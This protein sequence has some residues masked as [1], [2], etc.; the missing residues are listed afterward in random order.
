MAGDALAGVV[1]ASRK[2]AAP[3]RPRARSTLGAV[4]WNRGARV[5]GARQPQPACGAEQ[6]CVGFG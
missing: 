3:S 5:L 2:T 6:C 1:T 4:G